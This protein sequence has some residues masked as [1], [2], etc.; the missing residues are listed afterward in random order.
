[1][2]AKKPGGMSFYVVLLAVIIVMSVIMSRMTQPAPVNLSELIGQ[3]E[4]G[5]VSKVLVNGYNLEVTMTKTDG[6]SAQVY[7]K[8]VSP[9]WMSN[10]FD[11]L[12]EA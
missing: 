3:I 12:T 6:S 10:L 5:E 4:N 2:K 11:V 9:M 8:Q 1:M 7:S